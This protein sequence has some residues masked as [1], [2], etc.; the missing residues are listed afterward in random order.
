MGPFAIPEDGDGDVAIMLDHRAYH[1]LFKSING[2][3]VSFH[4]SHDLADINMCKQDRSYSI[5]I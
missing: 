5:L 4:L 2:Y 1:N 3:K